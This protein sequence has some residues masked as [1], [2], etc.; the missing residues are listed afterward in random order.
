MHIWLQASAK[1]SSIAASTA[2]SVAAHVMLVG[3]AVY[4]TGLRARQLGE[5]I[6]E[7]SSYLHYLPPPDRRPSS[8][9]VVE[10]LQYIDIGIN[11]PVLSERGNGLILEL[12]G[13]RDAK[14]TAGNSKDD[15]HAEAPAGPVDSRDS[16]YSISTSKR[17]PS[18]RLEAL[19]P[20]IRQS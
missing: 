7:R 12:A 2:I 3:A 1:G 15:A 9:D 11:G 14:R 6:E 17:Q 19:R 13:S 4:G 8:D 20:S 5:M 16:V 18:A 10:H